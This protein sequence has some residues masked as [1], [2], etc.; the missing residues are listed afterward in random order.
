M[1]HGAPKR[2]IDRVAEARRHDE[3]TPSKLLS[4]GLETVI[5]CS[6]LPVMPEK[7]IL[8]VGPP[9][10]GRTSTAAKLTRRAAMADKQVYPIAA[11]F[12]ATAGGAQLA[13]Y[14]QMEAAQV[15]AC[16]TPD[17]L[18]GLLDEMRQQK[19]RCII[20]LPSIVPFDHEDMSRLKDLVLAT[21]VE[22]VLVMSAEGHP[23]DL[24]DT[25]AAFG[26]VGIQY[27][28]LTK[29][30]VVRRR[31]GAVAGLASAG[32][33]LSHLATTPFIGGGL[34][35]ANHARLASL[36]IEDAVGQDALKGA[37]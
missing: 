22:P 31:G 27:T 11:D 12:D 19:K 21:G 10:H 15:R 9:G 33:T 25:A 4:S 3:S 2:F 20:D 14:L 5:N 23:E 24:A 18:F 6:P 35:P 36:L 7:D 8:L 30:D 28:I 32:L 1:W 16:Q 17:H 29:L 37:A 34:I 26:R 13:A